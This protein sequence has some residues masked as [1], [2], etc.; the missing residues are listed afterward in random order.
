MS[1]PKAVPAAYLVRGD[2]ATLLTD[3]LRRLLD[4]VVTGDDPGL[5][6]EQFMV[7]PDGERPVAAVLD[8][9]LT[10]PF[11]TDRRVV[12]VRNAGALTAEEGTRLAEYVAAPLPSTV[13]ILVGGGGTI[14]ASLV[15][16]V[17]KAGEL[18][19]VGLP[20]QA[21]D[22]TTWLAERLRAAPV[23]LDTAA[24]R[25]LGQHLGEDLGRL[26][27]IV[28]TLEGAYGPGAKVG[29]D[30]LE[31]YLGRAGGVAPWDLTDALDRGDYSEALGAL[32]RLLRFG[33]RHPLVV[34][35]TLHRHYAAMLRLDGSG[36]TTEAEAAKVLGLKGSTFPARKVLNQ[37]RKLGPVKVRRAITLLAEADV[38]LKGAK[39]WPEELVMEVLVA[40]LCQLAR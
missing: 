21:R 24:A 17:K 37:G 23:K 25:L 26:S 32:R 19:D 16:A 30:E 18:V 38:D 35:A 27:G 8:A 36:A 2:D 10:P 6:V 33:E 7:E 20:R 11:F 14:P 12:V 4:T 1:P 15:V 39:A 22:R 29:V 13:L 31:P 34:M 9:C 28:D 40:R 3:A 5:A